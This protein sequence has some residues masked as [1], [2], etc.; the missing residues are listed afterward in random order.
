[1]VFKLYILVGVLASRSVLYTVRQKV[2]RGV[3]FKQINKLMRINV[4]VLYCSSCRQDSKLKRRKVPTPVPSRA[5][6][7]VPGIR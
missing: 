5:S 7:R 6:G 2:V 1:M 4:I 3:Y